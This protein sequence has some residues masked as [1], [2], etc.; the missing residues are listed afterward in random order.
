M[1]KALLIRKLA[2]SLTSSTMG[3]AGVMLAGAA[4]VAAHPELV[5]QIAPKWGGTIVGGAAFAVAIARARSL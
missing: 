4:W 5:A 2:S 1:L 3:V